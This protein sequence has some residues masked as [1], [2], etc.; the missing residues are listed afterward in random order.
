MSKKIYNSA[1]NKTT[2]AQGYGISYNTFK[3]WLSTIPNLNLSTKTRILTPKQVEIIYEEF[4][5][6]FQN[7]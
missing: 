1:I 2:L 6:P 5:N 7:D 4:G 3:K